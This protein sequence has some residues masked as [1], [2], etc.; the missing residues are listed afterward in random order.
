MIIP[1]VD[2]MKKKVVTELQNDGLPAGR[3]L[4]IYFQASSQYPFNSGFFN[5]FCHIP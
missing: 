3:L 4:I 1:I 5:Q 2:V